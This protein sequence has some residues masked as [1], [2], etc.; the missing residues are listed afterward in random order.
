MAPK[1]MDF[2]D[3]RAI[4]IGTSAYRAGFGNVPMPAALN[5]LKAMQDVLVD[6]CG[7][8]ESR[9]EVFPDRAIVDGAFQEIAALIHETSGVLL[10]YYVGHGQLL[11]DNDLGLALV[12]TSEHPRARLS[13]SLRLSQFRQELRYNSDASVK[14]VILD[15]CCSGVA[16][17]Y[18]QGTSDLAEK[19]HLAAAIPGEGT[20]TWT[21]C[22]HAQDTFFE[23]GEQGLT[24]FTKFLVETVRDGIAAK[25]AEL[26][27]A[28]LH[29]EVER[30]LRAISTSDI[31]IK[32][33]PTLLFKGKVGNFAFAPNV[34]HRRRELFVKRRDLPARPRSAL[35]I[36]A[37]A[38]GDPIL[39]RLPSSV[40]DAS[41]IAGVLAEPTIGGFEV[42]ALIDI[43]IQDLRIALEDFL[44]AADQSDLVLIYYVGHGMR[45][46]RGRLHLTASD[47]EHSRLAA[48]AL[49][50]TWILGLLDN[51]G[52]KNQVVIV[53]CSYSGAFP[54]GY[55]EKGPINRAILTSCSAT[56]FALGSG[57]ED[58][59]RFVFTSG[60]VEGILT[61]KAVSK[62]SEYI[63]VDDAFEYA[64]RYVLE[65]STAGR[66]P[67]RW[68]SGLDHRIVL[69]RNPYFI[70]GSSVG[71]NQNKH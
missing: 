33:E 2:S 29:G 19:V 40:D 12:D 70:Y 54:K 13:T 20:Y 64:S 21:A 63:T 10:I 3:S 25:G 31:V 42:T 59:S 35:V 69:A 9:I 68:F 26:T 11:A 8:P 47:T 61:G 18:A 48:T 60:F 55:A 28:D 34:A 1:S 6:V 15:C 46:V 36:G 27:L 17:K 45:D 37:G 50:A 53:D 32:P 62:D 51:C 41:D 38:Y 49:P 39:K 71:V 24:Y 30:K 4:L 14:I 23:P 52:T 65:S 43:G 16:T 57:G 22:G 67:H 58:T 7:W 5:S 66:R 44:T 56:E